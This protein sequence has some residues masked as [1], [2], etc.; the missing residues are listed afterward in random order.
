MRSCVFVSCERAKL[1][2]VDKV[3]ESRIL[4]KVALVNLLDY[5]RFIAGWPQPITFPFGLYTL[6]EF[7]TIFLDKN[8]PSE[9]D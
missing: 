1:S 2:Q 6:S 7:A 3:K 4:L 5:A 9:T 8:N